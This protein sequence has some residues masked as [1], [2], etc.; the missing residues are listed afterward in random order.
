MRPYI[1]LGGGGHAKVVMEAMQLCGR[2]VLGFT[3]LTRRDS[4]GAIPWLGLDDV[5]DSYSPDDIWLVNGIGSVG[6]NSRRKGLFLTWKE[7][8]YSFPTIIHPSAIVSPNAVLEEGVQLMA[9]VIVQTGTRIGVNTIINTRTMIDHNG[10]IGEHVHIAPGCVLSG[11]VTVADDVHIGTGAV[12]IQ[13]LTIGRKSIV[14]AGAVVVRD[15]EANIK[16]A[17]VPA[18]K[19]STDTPG[20]E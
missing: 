12:A 6:D 11:N 16:V 1:V 18:R 7:K 2:T 15:V 9:G 14:G 19:I 4:I 10:L 17:G 8:G 20:K 3:D 5:V 13:G